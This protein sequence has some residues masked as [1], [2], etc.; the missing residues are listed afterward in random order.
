[1]L[2]G[3]DGGDMAAGDDLAAGLDDDLVIGDALLEIGDLGRDA[4][5]LFASLLGD[6]E[7]TEDVAAG[8][9][10]QAGEVDQQ[11]VGGGVDDPVVTG[12]EES[13]A[14]L[15]QAGG[16]A[17]LSSLNNSDISEIIKERH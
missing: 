12:S 8:V 2:G 10:D 7:V 9:A 1:L 13:L 11:V 3:E 5:A 17:L 4:G 15:W 6:G 14:F 16:V